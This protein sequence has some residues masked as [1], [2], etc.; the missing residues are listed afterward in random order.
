VTIIMARTPYTFRKEAL[1]ELPPF[2]PSRKDYTERELAMY[3]DLMLREAG[4]SEDA[5]FL[6]Q[7]HIEPRWRKEVKTE[8]GT[9]DPAISNANS[10][11]GQTMYN[12]QH[13]Q[14][15]KVNSKEQ[16]TSN[17]ASYYR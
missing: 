10:P 5:P 8:N 3:T 2:D 14:G 9:P 15:R 16:R 6:F 11:D 7:E 17:G 13:P 4:S 12:R 1:A